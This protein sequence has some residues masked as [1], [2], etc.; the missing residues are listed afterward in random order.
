MPGLRDH[1]DH[2]VPGSRLTC[3]RQ[4]ARDR[5]LCFVPEAPR[6]RC[7]A[8]SRCRGQPGNIGSGQR[9]ATPGRGTRRLLNDGLPCGE[10]V[11]FGKLDNG[12]WL[13]GIF[14]AGIV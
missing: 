3:L 2:Q 5:L 4:R 10:G 9:G 14:G 11:V 13:A 1:V 7:S 8:G 12:S 6:T